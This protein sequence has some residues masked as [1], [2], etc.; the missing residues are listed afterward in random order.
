[1]TTKHFPCPSCRSVNRLRT[2]ATDR[3]ELERELGASFQKTCSHCS[4]SVEVHVNDVRAKPI[5][6][7]TYTVWGFLL[8]L[9][10]TALLLGLGQ[11]IYGLF[12]LAGI[13]GLPVMVHRA[14]EKAATTFNHY[15][16]PV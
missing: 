1:M 7:I 5:H 15:K 12:L 4:A 10:I 13:L 9:V 2:F 6:L 11:N 3:V 14:V 8:L 16:L